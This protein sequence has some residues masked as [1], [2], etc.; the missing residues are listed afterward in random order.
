MGAR[1]VPFRSK[2]TIVSSRK[3]ANSSS[4]YYIHSALPLF[5]VEREIFN[6]TGGEEDDDDDSSTTANRPL[7]IASAQRK[8]I[9]IREKS[10]VSVGEEFQRFLPVLRK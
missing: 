8:M 9:W 2:S 3:G 6:Y 5:V 4:I 10:K 7:K 1:S